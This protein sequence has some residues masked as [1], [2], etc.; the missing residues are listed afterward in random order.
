MLEL[1]AGSVTT[2]TGANGSGKST[3]LQLMAGLMRPSAGRV[4]DR[5][6]R[7][8]YLPER[9]VPPASLDASSYLAHMGR[10]KGMSAKAIRLRRA[11]LADAF[12]V[13][14][15]LDIDL[16][17]LS[18]GNLQKVGL[19]QAFLAPEA[20]IVLDEPRTGLDESGSHVLDELIAASCAR[21][22][23]VLMSEHDPVVLDRAVR[24]GELLAGQL[25]WAHPSGQ[26]QDALSMR[27]RARRAAGDGFEVVV[28]ATECDHT[29]VALIR[30][31]CSV[32][33][34]RSVQLAADRFDSC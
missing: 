14:P 33:D 11:A 28:T 17:Q 18:K 22:A 10:L 23:A 15:G 27:I 25:R 9:F 31:G 6:K 20:L 1:P 13:A 3:L 24:V 19:I 4:R 12:A 2:V 7:V 8:G 34:V 16:D 5:P 32:V 30:Q 29:L 26:A 21:G